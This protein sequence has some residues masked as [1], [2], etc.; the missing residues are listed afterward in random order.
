MNQT[1]QN[2]IYAVNG[3][4]GEETGMSHNQVAD[5]INN[6]ISIYEFPFEVLQDVN[7][8]LSDCRDVHYAAQQ[9]RY[10]QNIV[11]AGRAKKRGVTG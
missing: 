5:E 10:L 11:S 2:V 8:R 6:L 9:L 1:T 3:Y 7:R 4:E